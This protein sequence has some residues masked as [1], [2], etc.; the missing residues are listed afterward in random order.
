MKI[1]I[2][3]FWFAIFYG[4]FIFTP[5]IAGISKIIKNTIWQRFQCFGAQVFPASFILVHFRLH[6]AFSFSTCEVVY[7]FDLSG[8]VFL[9]I[10]EKWETPQFTFSFALKKVKQS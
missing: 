5:F 3:F 10:L 8:I 7:S 1:L 6:D 9:T 4:N 2:V